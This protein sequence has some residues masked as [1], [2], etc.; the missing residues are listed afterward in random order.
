M[1]ITKNKESLSPRL[2]ATTM[3][4]IAK[5]IF[6]SKVIKIKSTLVLVDLVDRRWV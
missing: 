3:R 4:A 2:K 6:I 5:Q 1:I